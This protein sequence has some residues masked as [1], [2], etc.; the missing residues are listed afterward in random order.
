MSDAASRPVSGI[1][2][3]IVT[4]FCFVAVTALVKS[5]GNAIPAAQ[6]AFL[7]YVLGLVF[8]IPIAGRLMDLRLSR[9]EIG[10]FTARGLIHT[11][12]VM[13]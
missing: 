8:L 5:I 2:W 9:M 7:R 12:G 13:A 6:S 1:L 10:L 11:G 3:M 4:G